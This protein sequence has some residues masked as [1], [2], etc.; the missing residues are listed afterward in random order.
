MF[1]GTALF[2]VDAEGTPITKALPY[3][4]AANGTVL[5]PAA[6]TL[7]GKDDLEPAT[8]QALIYCQLDSKTKDLTPGGVAVWDEAMSVWTGSFNTTFS[9]YQ[10]IGLQRV[11]RKE[12][13]D[14]NGIR[15]PFDEWES[16]G[17]EN[18]EL[19]IGDGEAR[20]YVDARSGRQCAVEIGT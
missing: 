11:S 2:A 16:V 4:L 14:E 7:A 15:L 17:Q 6:L 1:N 18:W 12:T 19:T 13:A 5:I 8:H 20:V 10:K 9:D 3:S